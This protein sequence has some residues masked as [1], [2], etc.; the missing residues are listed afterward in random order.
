[1]QM[2]DSWRIVNPTLNDI[3]NVRTNA[4]KLRQRLIVKDEV[5]CFLRPQVS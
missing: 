2:G 3:S 4:R 5:Y 1:M